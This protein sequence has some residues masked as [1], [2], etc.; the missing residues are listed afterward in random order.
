[1][2]SRILFVVLSF[3]LATA[4]GS[5]DTSAVAT[6]DAGPTDSG[7]VDTGAATQDS[8]AAVD[9]GP[10]LDSGADK[11]DTASPVVDAG[12]TPDSGSSDANTSFAK[13]ADLELTIEVAGELLPTGAVHYYKFSGTKGQALLFSIQAQDVAYDPD[14][15]DT[16]LTLFDADKNK[17]AENDD[18]FP[19]VTN[20]SLLLT[21]LPATGVYYVSVEECWTWIAAKGIST[22]CGEPKD[23]TKTSYT[24]TMR[25]LDP[26]QPNIVPDD[27]KGDGIDSATAVSYG[28][29]SA[30]AYVLSVIYG[31]FGA[32]TDVDVFAFTPPMDTPIGKSRSVAYF[33]FYPSGVDG[34]GSTTTPGTVWLASAASPTEVIASIDLTKGGD[35]AAP[36]PL[37]KPFYIYI[38]H[39]GGKAG[40]NDFYFVNHR[41]SGGNP[42]EAKDS[43]NN[44]WAGAEALEATDNTT[45]GTSYFVE[46]NL[47]EAKTDKD[48]FSFAVPMGATHASV[49]CS[50]QRS[51]SGLRDLV[52]TLFGEDG[53]STSGLALETATDD[54]LIK[55]FVIPKGAKKLIMQVKAGSQADGV[56]SDYYRCGVHL[57]AK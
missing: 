35:I 52:V 56:S 16:V 53:S 55:D 54:A 27:E 17:I 20:D 10:A 5:S 31:T 57:S 30:G 11:V 14:S 42:V 43:E 39:A 3:S 6:T 7:A 32:I 8:G 24:L 13:A 22:G 4:C 26:T 49:I 21:I 18:P 25:E 19:R 41:V 29:T 33:D 45:G 36:L 46:G 2:S 48:H 51:G 37:N 40:A 15:L 44:T 9:A 50:A 38:P 12:G 23:K 47:T 1:M 34:N 28:K